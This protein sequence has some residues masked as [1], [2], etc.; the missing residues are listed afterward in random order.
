MYMILKIIVDHIV[1][2]CNKVSMCQTIYPCKTNTNFWGSLVNIKTN[3]NYKLHLYFNT[4]TCHVNII[5][6]FYASSSVYNFDFFIALMLYVGIA[7]DVVYIHLPIS[8][9]PITTYV[10]CRNCRGRCIYTS[11]YFISAH[12]HLCC[13]VCC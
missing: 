5:E 8:S 7:V 2:Q 9:V 12:H 13:E 1:A 4:L 3:D 10:I 6:H 11:T